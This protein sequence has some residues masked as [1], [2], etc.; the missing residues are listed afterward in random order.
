MTVDAGHEPDTDAAALRSAWCGWCGAGLV[1]PSGAGRPRKYCSH[2]CRQQAHVARKIAEAGGLTA[3][4]V[5]VARAD[6]DALLARVAALRDA[7]ADLDRVAPASGDAG[8]LQQAL[9]WLLSFAR[10][11]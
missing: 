6:Y 10:D 5:V 9:D 7:V 2:S 4:H 3:E 8:D 1:Q 11:V